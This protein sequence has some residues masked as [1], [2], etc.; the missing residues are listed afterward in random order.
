[1]GDVLDPIADFALDRA[2]GQAS[3][4]LECE[5]CQAVQRMCGRTRV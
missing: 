1:M 5:P 3:V 2:K 4:G